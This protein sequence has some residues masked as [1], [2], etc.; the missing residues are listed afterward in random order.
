MHIILP[1]SNYG[2][3]FHLFNGN[4]FNCNEIVGNIDVVVIAI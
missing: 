1:L 3:A 2:S 4:S